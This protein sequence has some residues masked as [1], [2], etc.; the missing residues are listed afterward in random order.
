[1]QRWLT[2]KFF[3]EKGI[4]FTIGNDTHYSYTTYGPFITV[5]FNNSPIKG[6]IEVI[7]DGEVFTIEDGTFNYD[8][9]RPLSEFSGD[10]SGEG[11]DSTG[12]IFDEIYLEY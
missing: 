3:D 8:D 10:N 5:Y 12:G 6:Q 7:K 11:G 4:D 9:P 1:M 2:Q